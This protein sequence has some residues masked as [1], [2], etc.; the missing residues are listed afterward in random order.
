MIDF[1]RT[2]ARAFSNSG[3]SF[4]FFGQVYITLIKEGLMAPFWVLWVPAKVCDTK[5]STG[6]Q[7]VTHGSCEQR[8][9]R[10]CVLVLM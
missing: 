4:G 6:Q 1:M 3:R 10:R 7:H 9:G 8:N 5:G 2:L